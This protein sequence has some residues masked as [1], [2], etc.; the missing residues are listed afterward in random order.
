M[1][2]WYTP[3][4]S[5]SPVPLDMV[6]RRSISAGTVLIRSMTSSDNAQRASQCWSRMTCISRKYIQKELPIQ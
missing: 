2:S 4:S 5:L 6:L 3:M 1:S